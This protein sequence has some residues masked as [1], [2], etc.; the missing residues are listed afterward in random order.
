[1]LTTV[2]SAVATERKH[3]SVMSVNL[4]LQT[5]ATTL[6]LQSWLFAIS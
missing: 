5:A 6:R 1:M 2:C 3:C 4:P